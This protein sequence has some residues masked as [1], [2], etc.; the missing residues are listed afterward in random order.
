MIKYIAADKGYIEMQDTS[1]TKYR[2]L[3]AFGVSQV[4]VICGGMSPDAMHSSSMDFAKE[5]GFE[6]H[7]AAWNT[8]YKGVED[9]IECK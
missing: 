5:Y 2:A 8:F 7:D 3:G 9:Y 4:L 6:S 1:G